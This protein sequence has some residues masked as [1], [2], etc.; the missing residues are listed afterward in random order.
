[1]VGKDNLNPKK[2]LE[3]KCHFST[4]RE[5]YFLCTIL[6]AL[7]TLLAVRN[8]LVFQEKTNNWISVDLF[9]NHKTK[10]SHHSCA[11]VVQFNSTLSKFLEGGLRT[12]M[13]AL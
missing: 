11:S 2:L 4:L 3:F 1:M 8:C 10:N 6:L 9:V 13:L 12:M 7:L 5:K